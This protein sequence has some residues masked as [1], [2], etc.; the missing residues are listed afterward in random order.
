M[1][2][3]E[4]PRVRIIMD[5]EPFVRAQLQNS[6]PPLGGAYWRWRAL[7]KSLPTRPTGWRFASER[8]RVRTLRVGNMPC[9]DYGNRTLC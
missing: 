9:V 3:E 1:R 5:I 7:P 6:L 2:P 4:F 8:T